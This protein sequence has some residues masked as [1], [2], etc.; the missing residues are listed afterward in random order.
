MVEV[1][2]PRK[3]IYACTLSV[4]FTPFFIMWMQVTFELRLSS[5]CEIHNDP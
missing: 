2:M 3:N 5:D 1:Y 4:V